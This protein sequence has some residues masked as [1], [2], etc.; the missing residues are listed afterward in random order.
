MQKLVQ[1]FDREFMFAYLKLSEY[2]CL[3]LSLALYD[4]NIML[5]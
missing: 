4:I 5:F 3:E 1:N 2:V